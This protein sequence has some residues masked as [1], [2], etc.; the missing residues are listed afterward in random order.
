MNIACVECSQV[1]DTDSLCPHRNPVCWGCCEDAHPF[2][3]AWEDIS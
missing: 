3:P 1:I 2:Q